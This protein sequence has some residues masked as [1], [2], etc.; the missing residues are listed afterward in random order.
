M[1]GRT[2]EYGGI[3]GH[4]ANR[5]TSA[6]PNNVHIWSTTEGL[7][8]H[9]SDREPPLDIRLEILFYRPLSDLQRTLRD[10]YSELKPTGSPQVSAQ[11]LVLINMYILYVFWVFLGRM[12]SHEV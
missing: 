9:S 12:D 5:S 3:S 8:H 7:S 11:L 2:N 4:G 6:F 10:K 1:S